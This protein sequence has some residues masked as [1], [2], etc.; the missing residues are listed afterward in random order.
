MD[1]QRTDPTP[2]SDPVWQRIRDRLAERLPAEEF[3]TWVAPLRG[4][5]EGDHLVL[6][7][8]NARIQNTVEQ[9]YLPLVEACWREERGEA[10]SVAVAVAER[11]GAG[12]AEAPPAPALNA[13]YRF[14]TF[15]V[16]DSNQF[17]HA[18]ARAVAES[19]SRSYNPLFLYGGVGL[20]KTHLLHAICQSLLKS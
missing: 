3:E 16:G 18:A 2:M 17:A 8:G 9:E 6:V 11:R 10:A 12:A 4:R 20:G 19:P 1:S 13:K 14:E 5:V 7:A 15:V